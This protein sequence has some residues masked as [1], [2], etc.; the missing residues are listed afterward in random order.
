MDDEPDVDRPR[1]GRDL[2]NPKAAAYFTS[3]FAVAV[4]P[5]APLWFDAVLIAS[6]VAIAAGWYAL[7]APGISADPV[8]RRY[9]GLE[10]AIRRLA[11]AVFIA[12]GARQA[13][14]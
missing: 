14:D 11:G 2:S 10:R 1:L 9:R 4:P 6:V 12:F 5:G 3:L 8:A 7:V 13:L